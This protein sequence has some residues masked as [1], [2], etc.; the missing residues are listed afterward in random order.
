M[1]IYEY[2]EEYVRKSL[3]ETGYEQGRLAGIEQ[4]KAKTLIKSIDSIMKN[5]NLDLSK[6]CEIIGVTQEEYIHSKQMEAIQEK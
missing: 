3:T 2:N 6:A 5:L 1:S 4:G